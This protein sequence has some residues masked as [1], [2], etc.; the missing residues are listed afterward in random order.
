VS[1]NKQ[2]AVEKWVDCFHFFNHAE[3]EKRP[4]R[5]SYLWYNFIN[6]FVSDREFLLLNAIFE[7]ILG[8]VR[9][10]PIHMDWMGLEKIEKKFDL[11]GIKTHSIPLN[12]HGLRAN[13]TSLK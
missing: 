4:L 11:F 7:N 13:R 10:F 6:S 12:P 9:L 5:L 3:K 2:E 1:R 8:L